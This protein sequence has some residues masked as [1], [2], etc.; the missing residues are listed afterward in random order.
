MRDRLSAATHF[1]AA[2]VTPL[3]GGVAG[4][5]AAAARP[6]DGDA[7]AATAA[8]AANVPAAV[9]PAAAGLPLPLLLAGVGGVHDCATCGEAAGDGLNGASDGEIAAM[10]DKLLPPATC[11]LLRT[12]KRQH[13]AALPPAPFAKLAVCSSRLA[14][15]LAPGGGAATVAPAAAAAPA[16][17][18]PLAQ[19]G[20]GR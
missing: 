1:P 16:V 10:A 7:G 8:A 4:V 11:V 20:G 19:S 12:A 14:P 13:P 3:L 9:A 2:A 6:S 5:T 15:R 18:R 17:A